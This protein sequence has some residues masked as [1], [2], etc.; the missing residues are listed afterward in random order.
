VHNFLLMYKDEG[1]FIQRNRPGARYHSS[2][3]KSSYMSLKIVKIIFYGTLTPPH[4]RN[5][6][7]KT[8]TKNQIWFSET[9]P[10]E[11]PMYKIS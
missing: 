3:D 10:D 11:I 8:E 2:A 4:K 6:G 5:I 9:R 7:R 1:R